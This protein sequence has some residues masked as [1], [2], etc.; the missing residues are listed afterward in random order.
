MDS[1]EDKNNL[2]ISRKA[3]SISVAIFILIGVFFFIAGFFWGYR[4]ASSDVQSNLNKVNF[5]DHINYATS[6]HQIKADSEEVV[7]ADHD[8]QVLTAS[9]TMNTVAEA[10]ISS[11]IDVQ[12]G[13]QYYAELIG[14]GH[15]RPAQAFVDKMQKKGYPIVIK[16]RISKNG[17]GKTVNW[18][19][20][21]TENCEDRTKLVNLI[22]MIKKTERLKDIK[23]KKA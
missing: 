22:E 12:T 13:Q 8:S 15:L 11:D 2:I 6:Q 19:Q 10:E 23:I 4:H 20:A 3:A 7:I 17:T 9:P 5:S 1:I 16:K 14:F 21:V 18:Y